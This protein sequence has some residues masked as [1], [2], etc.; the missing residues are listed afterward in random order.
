MIAGAK[1]HGIPFQREVIMGGGTDAWE[2]TPSFRAMLPRRPP[3]PFDR[4]F[5]QKD[6]ELF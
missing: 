5:F 2:T 4:E 1:K 6:A 3:A